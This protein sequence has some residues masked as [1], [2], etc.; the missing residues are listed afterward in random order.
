M[1]QQW[2]L[3]PYDG[4]T[5]FHNYYKPMDLTPLEPTRKIKLQR[6]HDRTPDIGMRI[7]VTM[8]HEDGPQRKEYIG[9]YC[10]HG[11]S[12][13]AFTLNGAPGD[14]H[15]GKILKVTTKPDTEPYM[16]LQK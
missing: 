8:P 3:N 15:D 1:D 5:Q 11:Q 13:T 4:N 12:K 9:E 2:R 6:N 14:P 10:G 16:Y 7:R